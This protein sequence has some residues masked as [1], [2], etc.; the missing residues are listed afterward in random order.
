[1]KGTPWRIFAFVLAA[2]TTAYSFVAPDAQGFRDPATAR[3]IFFHLPAALTCT[4]FIAIA[5]YLGF[6][7]LRTRERGWDVRLAAATELGALTGALALSTGMLFSKVQW[8]EW[9]QW[10]PRQ[11]SFLIVMMLFMVALALRAGHSDEAR[12]AGTSSAYALLM[13]LPAFFLIFVFPRLPQVQQVSFHPSQTVAKG[14]FDTW[15]SLG[16]YGNLLAL[17][18]V[19]RMVYLLRVKAGLAQIA[20]E[21]NYELDNAGGGHSPDPGVVRPVAVRKER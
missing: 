5:A 10:D 12:R 8:G 19:V 15:Y 17:S 2:V 6:K 21:E 16:V 1:M 18:L 14:G 7:Y 4:A 13:L 20:Y 11:T 9:W 3:I